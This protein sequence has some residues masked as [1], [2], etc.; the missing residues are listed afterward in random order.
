MITTAKHDD[1][2]QKAY[3]EIFVSA[4]A[5]ILK[6]NFCP[7]LKDVGPDD[8]LD[9]SHGRVE[10]ADQERQC[11]AQ[12]HLQACHLCQ[13]QGGRVDHDRQVQAG[14]DYETD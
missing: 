1:S 4:V 6:F 10:D 13:G 3:M 5:K 7:Y 11:D 9:A 14:Q 12:V 2:M 8:S